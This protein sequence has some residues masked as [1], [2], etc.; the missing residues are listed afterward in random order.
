MKWYVSIMY[1]SQKSRVWA[2]QDSI[3]KGLIVFIV[4]LTMTEKYIN[5]FQEFHKW[6]WT[7]E[8][9]RDLPKVTVFKWQS[10]DSNMGLSWPPRP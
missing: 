6:G 2:L 3:M 4:L 5:A 7:S 8:G 9:L 1:F 10:L